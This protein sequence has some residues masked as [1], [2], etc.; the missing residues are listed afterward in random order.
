MPDSRLV[1]KEV[2][3]TAPFSYV[4][5]T[6]VQIAAARFR[7]IADSVVSPGANRK[8]GIFSNS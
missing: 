8:K 4:I 5:G 2:L 3:T 1:T 7:R 6:F